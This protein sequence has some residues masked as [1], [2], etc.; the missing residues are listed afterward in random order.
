MCPLELTALREHA[1]VSESIK[2]AVT[3]GECLV[4]RLVGLTL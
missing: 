4:L 1:Y 2:P 3:V